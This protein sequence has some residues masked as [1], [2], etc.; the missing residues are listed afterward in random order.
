MLA[1]VI[2][3]AGLSLEVIRPFLPDRHR[4]CLLLPHT[5]LA[6]YSPTPH[7][8]PRHRTPRLLLPLNPPPTP[9]QPFQV[10][11][12]IYPQNF[13]LLACTGNF[14][15]ALGKGMSKP[16]F[17]SGQAKAAPFHS[18]D[19]SLLV[20]L[21]THPQSPSLRVIQTHFATSN[22]V[23]AV[24]AKEEVWEVVGQLTGYAASLALLQA[25]QYTGERQGGSSTDRKV[26]N[27]LVS[28][29][30]K[31]LTFSLPHVLPSGSGQ[32]QERVIMAWAGIQV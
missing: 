18:P 22:N 15:K 6:S 10:M 14:A 28:T 8:P 5:A 31:I 25:L 11:T 19:M 2:T 17:R 32:S 16:A 3:T 24:A 21:D 4:T 9:P 29:Q 12:S 13:L 20:I 23:G 1:E 26:C 27:V 7:L 30:A